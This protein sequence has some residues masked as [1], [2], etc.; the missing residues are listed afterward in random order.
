M[1]AQ[2]AAQVA[3]QDK[4]M[5]MKK[6][7]AEIVGEYDFLAPGR[8]MIIQFTETDGKLYGAPVGEPAELISPVEG[9]PLCF[10]VTVA[11][12]GDYYI[13]QFVRNDK[14]VIDKCI[15]TVQGTAIEGTKI[16]KSQAVS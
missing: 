15:L 9:T 13:L 8:S 12:S 2:V 6:L 7:L 1:A 16:I 14:G 10:D 3:A 5:D 11:D 4:P